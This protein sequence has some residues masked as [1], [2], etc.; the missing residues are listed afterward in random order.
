MLR[1]SGSCAAPSVA[2]EHADESLAL[3]RLRHGRIIRRIQRGLHHKHKF[4]VLAAIL[5]QALIAQDDP[6]PVFFA[7]WRITMPLIAWL[8]FSRRATDAAT[9]GASWLRRGS[10]REG[11]EHIP[12]NICPNRVAQSAI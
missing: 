9:S 3:L 6:A 5:E 11:S 4:G 12:Y 2:E 1:A 10:D 7:A 8:C